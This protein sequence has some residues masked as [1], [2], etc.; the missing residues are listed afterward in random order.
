MK[1]ISSKGLVLF[2]FII[3]FFSLPSAS[4]G[5][6]DINEALQFNDYEKA[7][8]LLEKQ[9]D[10]IKNVSTKDLDGVK[11]VDLYRSY[12]VLADN[13]AWHLNEKDKALAKLKELSDLRNK[14]VFFNDIPDIENIYMAE[15]YEKKTDIRRSK[16]HYENILRQLNTKQ[17]KKLDSDEYIMNE[18]MIK[19]LSFKLDQLNLKNTQTK[20]QP[21]KKL[22]PTYILMH[23][24]AWVYMVGFFVPDDDFKYNKF[25]HNSKK[26]SLPDYIRQSNDDFGTMMVNIF[27]I[28]EAADKSIDDA[29]QS[30]DVFVDKYPDNYFTVSL[31]YLFYTHYLKNNQQAKA[32]KLKSILDNIGKRNQIEIIT[33]PD[34]RFSS[35]QKTW[36]LHQ[37]ALLSGNIELALECVFPANRKEK[38]ETYMSLGMDVLK[39]DAKMPSELLED[40]RD[41]VSASYDIKR[42]NWKDGMLQ[43]VHFVNLNGEWLIE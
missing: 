15:I 43:H 2:V 23:H 38:K 31:V 18:E 40:S 9:I 25:H 12:F 8:K 24:G 13:Y 28:L 17:E 7:A 26:L 32:L 16:E 21:I 11:K 35:P 4:W 36:E 5:S 22:K 30:L 29:N 10:E 3:L 20:K 37:S 19:F 27:F 6:K 14:I 1:G 41:E 34:K 42:I 39:Q 33:E